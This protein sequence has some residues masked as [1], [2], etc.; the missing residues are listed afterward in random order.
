MSLESVAGFSEANAAFILEQARL[1]AKDRGVR[2]PDDLQVDRKPI[3]FYNDTGFEIPPYGVLQVRN[4]RNVATTYHDVKRPIDYDA[5]MTTMLINGPYAVPVGKNGTAQN[6]P[7]YRVV[8][9]GGP[10]SIGDRL[11]WSA[12]SFFVSLG[13]LL[14][15]LGADDV[16]DNCLR[17]AFDYST[18]TGQ[19][20]S[21]IPAG[22]SG[23]FHR[24][25]K[26]SSSFSTNTGRSYECW[27]DSSTEI[28]SGTRILA[29]PGE[30]VW[31][32]VEVC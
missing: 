30:G 19:T 14:V 26:T 28:A 22:G 16:V 10:Y 2:P 25:K 20:T 15:N 5:C 32:A 9:D 29:F 11:G 24:R 18:M 23:T 7:V 21:V 1:F 3:H 12:G 13:S 27:N 31:L 6:G 4:V 8:H 17:V